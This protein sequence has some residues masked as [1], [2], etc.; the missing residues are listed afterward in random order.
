MNRVIVNPRD[1]RGL[2]DVVSPKSTRDFCDY[3]CIT[4]SS[5]DSVYGTVYTDSYRAGSSLSVSAD[6]VIGSATES[7]TVSATLKDHSDVVI[8]GATVH[9]VVN[10]VDTT[11]TT[12][13]SGVA[14]LTVTCDGSSVY[15]VKVYYIGSS[16]DG[17]CFASATVFTI[18]VGNVDLD[19]FVEKSVIQ[20]GEHDNLI[21][22]LSDGS[23]GVPNQTVYFYEEYEPST[24]LLGSD[25]SII[26]TGEQANLQ[27][28]LKDADGSLVEGETVDYYLELDS[29]IDSASLD[30]S[31]FYTSTNCERGTTTTTASMTFSTNK[32]SLSGA[33]KTTMFLLDCEDLGNYDAQIKVKPTSTSFSGAVG[34]AFAKREGYVYGVVGYNDGTTRIVEY[35][36]NIWQDSSSRYFNGSVDTNGIMTI[37]ASK[38]GNVVSLFSGDESTSLTLPNGYDKIGVMIG[39]GST[40]LYG[41]SVREVN[42]DG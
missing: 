2:G 34:F 36:H 21:A 40:E 38:R 27:A 20:T 32:Y 13:G 30:K 33:N 9:F 37:T 23:R 16:N 25:K 7:F 17:G 42:S 6:T 5:T 8:S 4:V 24:L 19:L 26:Q 28:T 41:F 31:S 39:T 3:N 11:A 10:D 18:D 22:I 29:F 1:V 14:S 12:N 35:Y 15:R